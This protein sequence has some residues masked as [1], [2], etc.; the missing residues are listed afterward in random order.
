MTGLTAQ[1]SLYPLEQTDLALA[2]A[3]IWQARAMS[4]LA[5][6]DDEAVFAALREGFAQAASHGPAVMV[7]ALSNAC[8]LPT[9]ADEEHHDG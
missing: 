9:D 5:S 4:T 8:P 6:G 2:I 1:V 7:V 3:E